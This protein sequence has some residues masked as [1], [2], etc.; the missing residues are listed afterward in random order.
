VT[1]ELLLAAAVLVLATGCTFSGTP[2]SP[3][4]AGTQQPS[5]PTTPAGPDRTGISSPDAARIGPLA[6]PRLTVVAAAGGVQ[7]TWPTTGEDL[8]YYQCLRRAD[9]GGSWQQIGRTAPEQLSYLDR[10]PRTGTY[11]Y[12]VQAVNPAG[13]GSP[14]AESQPISIG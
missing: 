9:P 1:R 3:S 11:V 2:T 6:P 4:N 7:L 14:I 12:G 13:L 5:A 10:D 8:A